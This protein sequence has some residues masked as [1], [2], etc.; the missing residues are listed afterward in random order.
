ALACCLRALCRVAWL[1]AWLVFRLAA[2][3]A[4]RADAWCAFRWEALAAEARVCALADGAG[5]P[6]AEAAMSAAKKSTR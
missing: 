1:L 5:E 4:V 2:W 3:C 6:L